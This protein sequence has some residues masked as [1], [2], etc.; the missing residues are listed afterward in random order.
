MEINEP[1]V[2]Y[3]DALQATTVLIASILMIFK[4]RLAY[5]FYL[6]SSLFSIAFFASPSVNQIV[7]IVQLILFFMMYFI[8]LMS[9]DSK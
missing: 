7:P 6:I 5:V 8:G 2:R 1:W 3:I 4:I 9:W